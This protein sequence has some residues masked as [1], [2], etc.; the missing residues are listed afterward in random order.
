MGETPYLRVPSAEGDDVFHALYMHRR[1]LPDGPD[2]RACTL[3][4]AAAMQKAEEIDA[5]RA[6]RKK[7][8]EK[9]EQRND[10]NGNLV[11]FSIHEIEYDAIKA[12]CPA[13]TGGNGDAMREGWNWVLKQTWAKDFKAPKFEKRYLGVG[14]AKN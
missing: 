11:L 14:N 13:I 3:I 7:M 4:L 10:I 5:L 12:L 2:K 6:N 8:R 9:L 1:K